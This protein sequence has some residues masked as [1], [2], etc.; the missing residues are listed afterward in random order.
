MNGTGL[1]DVLLL[2]GS[3]F[4]L[5][6]QVDASESWLATSPVRQR[7]IS[8]F[9]EISEHYQELKGDHFIIYALNQDTAFAKSVLKSAE[10]YYKT[11]A[12]SLDYP[13]YDDFW[14]WEKRC[15]IVIL[16]TRELFYQV[17]AQEKWV[18]GFALPV[19]RVIAAHSEVPDFVGGV[20]P[21]EITHLLLYDYVEGAFSWP[22]WLN[23]GLAMFYQNSLDVS[24]VVPGDLQE[25]PDLK[26]VLFERIAGWNYRGS[27]ASADQIAFFYRM[28][29]T[30]V[31]WWIKNF[32][33]ESMQ[34]FIKQLIETGGDQTRALRSTFRRES[35]NSFKDLE[36]LWMGGTL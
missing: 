17:T 2:T 13:R 20:L 4:F 11:I 33:E 29:Y 5:S 32:G 30:I 21:H 8:V 34:A 26:G 23:E 31:F 35:V 1:R 19:H 3:L 28:S 15:L 14:T 12:F 18:E 25:H 22:D 27:A 36:T 6:I 16:P 24:P 10:S 9:G 7:I